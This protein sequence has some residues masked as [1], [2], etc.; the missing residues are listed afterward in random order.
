LVEQESSLRIEEKDHLER[1][2]M[3]LKEALQR[4]EMAFVMEKDRFEY[5]GA[6]LEKQNIILKS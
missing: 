1:T 6:D 3:E 5:W 2:V 4:S